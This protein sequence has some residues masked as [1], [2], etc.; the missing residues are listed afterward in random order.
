MAGGQLASS[1]LGAL[2]PAT[3]LFALTPHATNLM[4]RNR[5]FLVAVAGNVAVRA[6]G[7]SADVTLTVLA[8]VIYPIEI[9][10]LR[11]TGTTATG[12]SGVN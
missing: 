1:G 6:V 12:I 2:A 3:Q 5:G 10:Y 11:V 7:S 8:G 9:A 4:P